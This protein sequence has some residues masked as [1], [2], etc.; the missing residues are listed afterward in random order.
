[1]VDQ[2]DE[3]DYAE[4]IADQVNDEENNVGNGGQYRIKTEQADHEDH[5]DE[6]GQYEYEEGDSDA[7]ESDD[8]EA[9]AAEGKSSLINDY[10][11]R[12]IITYYSF[13]VPKAKEI[14]RWSI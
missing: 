10:Q 5:E 14:T 8:E 6:E 4:E 2:G 9:Q 3:T 11:N 7:V 12:K 13:Q 1:M